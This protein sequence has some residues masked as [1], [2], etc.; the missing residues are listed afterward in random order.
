[1]GYEKDGFPS[2][3]PPDPICPFDVADAFLRLA[4]RLL[5]LVL[6]FSRQILL[7]SHCS[8]FFF[9]TDERLERFHRFLDHNF[10]DRSDPPVV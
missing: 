6:R 9:F 3:H 10:G 1:M 8:P 7:F 2:T 4:V 5:F